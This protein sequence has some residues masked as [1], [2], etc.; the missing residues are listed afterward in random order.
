MRDHRH[1]LKYEASW[2]Y[3]LPPEVLVAV[4]ADVVVR[5]KVALPDDLVALLAFDPQTFSTYFALA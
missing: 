2:R 1:I 4:G 5:V 3:A